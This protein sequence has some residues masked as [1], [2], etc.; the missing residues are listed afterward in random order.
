MGKPQAWWR[1]GGCRVMQHRVTLCVHF[2]Q[3]S[4]VSAPLR[5]RS[6]GTLKRASEIQPLGGAMQV[7]QRLL[8][9]I[10]VPQGVAGAPE[11]T[12]TER[13]RQLAVGVWLLMTTV[14]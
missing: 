5:K 3:L 1:A 14:S 7:A 2:A 8:Q 4:P 13:C 11:A 9:G 12:T 10:P 6:L